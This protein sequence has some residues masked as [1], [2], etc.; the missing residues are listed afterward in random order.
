MEQSLIEVAVESYAVHLLFIV[1][2]FLQLHSETLVLL[3]DQL[4][5]I[6]C[7]LSAVID[8]RFE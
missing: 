3:I 5:L 8:Q 2:Y 7:V 4:D 6:D 1:L